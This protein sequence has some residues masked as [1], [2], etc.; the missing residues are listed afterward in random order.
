MI[1]SPVAFDSLGRY[2][3][4]VGLLTLLT[5]RM[6]SLMDEDSVSGTG[7]EFGIADGYNGSISCEYEFRVISVRTIN[8]QLMKERFIILCSILTSRNEDRY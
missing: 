7:F 1:A 8:L 6:P 5:T 4:K 3:V 2:T